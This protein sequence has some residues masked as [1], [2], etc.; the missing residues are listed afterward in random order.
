MM[1]LA[2]ADWLDGCFISPV[3]TQISHVVQQ[4]SQ[5][6]SNP[7]SLHFKAA[8]RVLRYLKGSPRRGLFFP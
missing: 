8:H 1:S 2:I 4:L 6:L 5:F 7:T 3:L